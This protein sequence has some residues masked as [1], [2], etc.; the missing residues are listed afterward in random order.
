MKIIINGRRLF[1]SPST[2]ITAMGMDKRSTGRNGR[3]GKRWKEV[4]EIANI[5]RGLT[6]FE[7]LLLLLL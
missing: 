3:K 5:S 6:G 2:T 4:R 1:F 7:L